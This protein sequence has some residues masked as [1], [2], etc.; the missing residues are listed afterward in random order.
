[1][2]TLPLR[3]TGAS[4]AALS[5]RLELPV[6]GRPKGYALFAHCFTCGKNL[7]GAVAVSRALTR[8]GIGVLRFDFTGLGES[9][10]DFADTHF[11]SNVAD[12]VAAA[13]FLEAEYD[14]PQLLVGH[15]LGGAAVL[16]AAHQLP[17]VRAV[18]TIG[19]PSAPDHVLHLLEGSLPEIEEQGEA[20]IR[21]AGRAFTIRKEFLADLEQ[22]TMAEVV[23]SLGRAL[24]ILHSP[25]D[26]IVGIGNAQ[27]LYLKARHPKSF[28]SL[29]TADHLLSDGDDA[30]YAAQVIAA[31]AT[32]Y[33][34]KRT[35]PD[36]DELRER[37]RVVVRTQ[38]QHYRTDVLAGGHALLAD[39]PTA[40]GG[41]DLGPS[42]YDL[43]AAG[44]GAC[45]SI[46]LRMYA[47]RKGWPLEEVVVRVRHDRLHARDEN[48]NERGRLDHMDRE[49][50]LVGDL[51]DEQRQ[52]LVAIAERCPV[53]RTLDAG[54]RTTTSLRE[55]A[56]A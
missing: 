25:V 11:S 40:L 37:D 19:A 15:S 2:A 7:R 36:L 17:S 41:Q 13:A 9:E 1:M 50:E 29:D 46:T 10:G 12:L 23:Q 39:E 43:I 53:H 18:A 5:A 56:P 49:I 45:T 52:R 26:Q 20:T 42:P 16:H 34:D 21:L 35:A 33:L 47:D 4:G 30:D 27:E 54:V 31:W 6:D 8:A 48:V 32:R 28:V 44:L 55:A 38:R 14:A 24:L 22:T 51:D 3:F